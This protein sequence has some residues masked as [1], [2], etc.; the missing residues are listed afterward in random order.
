MDQGIYEAC[1]YVRGSFFCEE[2]RPHQEEI[3]GKVH[4]L[5]PDFKNRW[6]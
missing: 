4:Y 2:M 3:N 6:R 5:L 1:G